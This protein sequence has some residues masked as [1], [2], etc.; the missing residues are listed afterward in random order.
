MAYS[1]IGIFLNIS[2]NKNNPKYDQFIQK[3]SN[4]PD[5]NIEPF[6]NL[7]KVISSLKIENSLREGI[8]RYK[9]FIENCL[10]NR[11]IKRERGMSVIYYY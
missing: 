9:N 7:Y 2:E 8:E 11:Q 4:I 6:L 5:L 3:V 1:V 10:A